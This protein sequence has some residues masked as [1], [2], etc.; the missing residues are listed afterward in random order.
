M[1]VIGITFGNTSSSIAVAND[2][3]VDVIANPDG[4]RAIPLAISYAGADEYHGFQ[5]MQQLIRNAD[6]TVINFR[7][8]LGKSFEQISTSAASGAAPKAVGSGVG[9]E[10]E[11]DGTK[12]TLSVE[13]VTKRHL[14]HLKHAAEDYTGKKVEG[15]VI[16]VPTDFTEAQRK[17]LSDVCGDA[18][19]KVLQ[20]INEPLAALLAY[21]SADE[22][23]AEDK[24]YVVADFGGVR[25]DAAVIVVR[26][27]V[28]T[29]LATAHDHTLGGAQLDAALAD[30]FAKEFQK[31]TKADATGT[32]RSQAKLTAESIVVKKTLSNVATSTCSIESLADGLDFH[33]TIN[34]MRFELAGRAPLSAMT[35]FVEKVVTKAGLETLDIDEVLLVGGS[36][37]VPKLATNILYLFPESTK[38]VAPALDPKAVDPSELIARGAALQASLIEGFDDEEIAELLQPVVVNTQHLAKSIGIKDASGAFVPILVA[39]TAFPIKKSIQVSNGDSSAVAVELY[40]GKRT[41]KETVVEPEANDEDDD[42]SDFSDDE[43]EVVREVVYEAGEKLAELTVKDLAPNATVEVIVNIKQ[44]GTLQLS[45][46][47][48]KQGLT[49]VSGE[50]KGK[51]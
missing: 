34:R 22:K 29:I 20:T 1:S 8:F 19:I 38:V 40:E 45:G 21:L 13:E 33:T 43:P 6:N 28:M 11:I 4:D 35:A 47:E 24:V 46:R 37:N 15:A 12:Q 26:G 18:G 50:I 3:K 23:L 2:G 7:D 41:V 32:A 36:S 49:A 17:V 51:N 42:D 10:V 48:L 9:F 44:D 14:N 16:T 30:F 5:A 27:G 39:E 25:S 31:K